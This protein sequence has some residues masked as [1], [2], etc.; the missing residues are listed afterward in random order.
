MR[1]HH[2]PVA[3]LLAEHHGRAADEFLSAIM[4][5]G[6]R[7]LLPR[8]LPSGAAMAPDHGHV[9]G[10]D[11]SEVERSPIARL[12]VLAIEL[13]QP[14][15]VIAS[16][17]G[18]AIEVEEHRLRCLAPDAIELLPVEARIGVDILRVQLQQLLAIALRA[19]DQ[20]PLGHF[21]LPPSSVLLS[22]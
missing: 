14:K 19:A 22:D 16:V 7:R 20:I 18:M 21:I 1:V 17:V 3:V 15:P 5:V 12:H 8:P 13:P 9:L 11:S 4:D 10:D 6:G 2:A